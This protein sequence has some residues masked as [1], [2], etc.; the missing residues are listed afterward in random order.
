LVPELPEVETIRRVL[1]DVLPQRLIRRVELHQPDMLDGL[2]PDEFCSQLKGRRMLAVDRRGKFLLIRLDRGA[3]L[4]HLGMTGQIFFCRNQKCIP[5][6]G[7][8]LRDRHTHLILGLSGGAHLYFRD[9]RRFGRYG[10]LG[11]EEE[12]R[13]SARL[14][15]E[16]L[17]PRFTS[18]HLAEILRG[19][20][21][22]IKALLMD[23][24]VVAGMGNIYADESLFRAGIDPRTPAGR[25]SQKRIVKLHRALRR[26][27]REG[28]H[29]GGTTLSD[30]LDPRHVQGS[31]QL[32][33]RVYGRNGEQC[34]RC[35]T[36]IRKLRVAQRGTHWCPRCQS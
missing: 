8:D 32:K 15:P 4:A 11:R 23:Q 17:G 3:L 6:A 31:F 29:H 30:Y 28:I 19:R 1:Q 7:S 18:L 5:S 34:T 16:P 21:A 25:L 9:S 26:V 24:R 27:L 36:P 2:Q 12:A 10:L 20:R 13:L 22:A 14:G 35:R 33:L